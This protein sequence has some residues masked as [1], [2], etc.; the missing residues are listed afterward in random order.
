MFGISVPVHLLENQTQLQ[1]GKYVEQ[2][3]ESYNGSDY[4]SSDDDRQKWSL[5]LNT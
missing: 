1:H 4:F 5:I 3:T 2:V